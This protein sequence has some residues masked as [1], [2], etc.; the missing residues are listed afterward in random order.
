MLGCVKGER[1]WDGTRTM[2]D[3]EMS[4]GGERRL[5]VTVPGFYTGTRRNKTYRVS[6]DTLQLHFEMCSCSECNSSVLRCRSCPF[7]LHVGRAGNILWGNPIRATKM[8]D[9][10]TAGGSHMDN[11]WHRFW[12]GITSLMTIAQSE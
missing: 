12:R 9:I 1:T 6:K 5:N 2:E 11:E 7:S 10:A 4:Q 8:C 3:A